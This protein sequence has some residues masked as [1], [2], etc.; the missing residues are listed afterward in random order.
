MIR[1]LRKVRAVRAELHDLG[2]LSPADCDCVV[3]HVR[4]P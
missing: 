3:I 2:C 4:F 1:P